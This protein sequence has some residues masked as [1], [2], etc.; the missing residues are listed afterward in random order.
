[1]GWVKLEN[2]FPQNPKVVGLSDA[3]FRA[4]VTALCYCDAHMTDGLLPEAAILTLGITEPVRVELVSN[5]LVSSRRGSLRIHDYLE[6]QRSRAQIASERKAAK[7]RQKRARASRRESRRDMGVSHGVSHGEVRLQSRREE[8]RE[9]P[10]CESLPKDLTGRGAADPPPE[11]HPGVGDGATRPADP[12]AR[13]FDPPL[14]SWPGPSAEAVEY[15][16]RNGYDPAEMAGTYRLKRIA[17][18]YRCANWDADFLGWCR[19]WHRNVL[20]RRKRQGGIDP[21]AETRR[22]DA[23]ARA[24]HRD[25]LKRSALDGDF[26]AKAKALAERGDIEALERGYERAKAK[27]QAQAGEVKPMAHIGPAIAIA[28]RKAD[29]R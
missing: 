10:I 20:D 1:M 2:T 8:K 15:L 12:T 18:A 7:E 26:G 6:H 4:Y 9:D 16:T 3:A 27:R 5:K 13:S 14:E 11:T 23:N 21:D 22:L 25:W 17:V 19:S 24:E 28:A 29:A